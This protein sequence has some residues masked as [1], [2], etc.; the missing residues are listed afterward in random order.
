MKCIPIII[1]TNWLAGQDGKV[2]EQEMH[3]VIL[4][5]EHAGKR[6]RPDLRNESKNQRKERTE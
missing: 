4:R 6:R 5:D 1:E 3:S 2:I